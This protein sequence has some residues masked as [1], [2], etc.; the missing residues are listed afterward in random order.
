MSDL[1][2]FDD[3][4]RKKFKNKPLRLEVLTE[5]IIRLQQRDRNRQ[6]R[7]KSLVRGSIASEKELR[8]QMQGHEKRRS[9]MSS[10]QGIPISPIHQSMKFNHAALRQS[11]SNRTDEDDHFNGFG[12]GN[13]NE[14]HEPSRSA[15]NVRMESFDHL[16]MANHSEVDMDE[17]E[18][19]SVET[20]REHDADH[21]NQSHNSSSD[22]ADMVSV[23][24]IMSSSSIGAQRCTIPIGTGQTLQELK[25]LIS[26]CLTDFDSFDESYAFFHDDTGF[27]FT[28]FQVSL[29]QVLQLMDIDP[30][31][32]EDVA[33]TLRIGRIVSKYIK[34]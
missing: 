6:H 1:S 29:R 20:E 9:S 24:I 17:K 25:A 27:I 19:Q 26:T 3:R 12:S 32:E 31:A 30:D 8:A 16:A 34:L 5:I 28:Q 15:H 23:E 18:K 4:K 14:L 21:N 13:D 2:L 22:R 33:I 10:F 7:A 11:V